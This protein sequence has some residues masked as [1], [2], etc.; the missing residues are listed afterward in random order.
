MKLEKCR[1]IIL[2]RKIINE[3]DVVLDVLCE[4]DDG[5]Y[6]KKKILVHGIIKS[7]KRSPV[8]AEIGNLVNIDYYE[9]DPAGIQS[10]KEIQLLERFWE[11]KSSYPNLQNL[12]TVLE[13][14]S[15]ATMT[16]ERDLKNVFVLVVSF[17]EFAQRYFLGKE[18]GVK[19]I[20]QELRLDFWR[21]AMLLYKIR[22]LKEMGLVG[23]TETCS[24]CKKPLHSSAKWQ[25]R[26][27][28][29]CKSCD[30][31]A[32]EWDY[33]LAM[34]LGA[35]KRKKFKEL[36]YVL[37]DDYIR[38][39]SLPELLADLEY[40]VEHQIKESIFSGRIT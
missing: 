25:E 7:R 31:T 27:Y 17:L 36:L 9:K 40:R 16:V 6:A 24:L 15:Y 2:S 26:I 8:V 13:L 23:D 33:R 37:K 11:L 34:L 18:D 39:A 30:I 10:S 22:I 35:F 21:I 19:Q 29:Y 3:I 38:N 5:M 20:L 1:G 32:N 4:M 14:A 28:F 12:T